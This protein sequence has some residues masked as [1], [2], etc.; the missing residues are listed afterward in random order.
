MTGEQAERRIVD[1]GLVPVV[2]AI[3]PER[4]LAA[5]EAAIDGGIAVVEITMTVPGALGVIAE[6][7]RRAG[8]DVLVGAGTVLDRETARR[9]LEAGAEFVVSPG[10]DAETVSFVRD[11]G[12]LMMA[13]AL[14][15]TEVL[16]A[17][18]AGSR[19][20]KVFPCGAMGG[21][22]YIAALKGPL[23]A[24][25]MVP[26]G[27]VNLSNVGE[28]IRRGAAAVGVGGELISAS[29]LASGDAAAIAVAAREYVKR[30][31]EARAEMEAGATKAGAKH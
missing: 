12:K 31:R 20:V 16:A 30:V 17:W 22:G 8:G 25:P 19:L 18:E 27:G 24:I 15:P 3:S 9:C 11:A 14:T 13:G 10:F 26:T 23:P 5:C 28:Y 2:R 4:A 21:P 29:A 1:I 7:A 6:L